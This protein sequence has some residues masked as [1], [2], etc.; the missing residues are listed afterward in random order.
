MHWVYIAESK[1]MGLTKVGESVRPVRRMEHH[2]LRYR[3]C[4]LLMRWPIGCWL[5]STAFEAAVMGLLDPASRV[6]GDWFAVPGRIVVQRA[7]A[8][9]DAAPVLPHEPPPKFVET[10]Q[11]RVETSFY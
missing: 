11:Y 8:L 3:D 10:E 5:Q 9:F 6:H 7:Q 4:A 2:R 1:G